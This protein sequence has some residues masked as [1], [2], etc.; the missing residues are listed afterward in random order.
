MREISTY[1]LDQKRNYILQRGYFRNKKGNVFYGVM[2]CL[3]KRQKWT[4][5]QSNLHFMPKSGKVDKWTRVSLV[6]VWLLFY[7]MEIVARPCAR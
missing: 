7:L 5:R 3:K 4:E 2:C 6:V 1:K